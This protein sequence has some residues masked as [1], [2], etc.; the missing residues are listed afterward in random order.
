VECANFGVISWIRS[1]AL[2]LKICTSW[3]NQKFQCRKRRWY[4]ESRNH[5]TWRSWYELKALRAHPFSYVGLTDELHRNF[6]EIALRAL[7]MM[8]GLR[9]IPQP[10]ELLYLNQVKKFTKRRLTMGN[11]LDPAPQPSVWVQ[12]LWFAKH[13]ARRASLAPQ[14]VVW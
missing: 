14:N 9:A 4:F 10:S 12:W 3:F 2:V 6:A 7:C 13:F 5:R 8:N 1:V 11:T